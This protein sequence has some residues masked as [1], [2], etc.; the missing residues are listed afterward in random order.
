MRSGGFRPAPVAAPRRPS[1]HHP[2]CQCPKCQLRLDFDGRRADEKTENEQ[3]RAEVERLRAELLA[4]KSS[5]K[6][7]KTEEREAAKRELAAFG[8]RSAARLRDLKAA[9]VAAANDPRSKRLLELRAKGYTMRA[10]LAVVEK[11][12]ED[13]K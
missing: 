9:A 6:Q 7:A 8:E 13:G 3:L 11:E 10:A 5:T 1:T 12:N 2:R 4:L